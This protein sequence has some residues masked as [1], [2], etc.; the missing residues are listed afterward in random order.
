VR[1]VKA[2][3][4]VQAELSPL[5]TRHPEVFARTAL[6]TDPSSRLAI[7][8]KGKLENGESFEEYS[9]AGRYSWK[10]PH[11]YNA[12]NDWLSGMTWEQIAIANE[13]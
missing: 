1:T 9:H 8:I 7:K 13:P 3:F 6:D 12:F 2:G 5:G 11:I 10:L 4:Y